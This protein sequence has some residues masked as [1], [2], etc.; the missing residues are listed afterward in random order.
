[1]ERFRQLLLPAIIFQSVLIG[2]AYATGREIVEYGARFGP[3]GLW[4]ML[5]IFIGFTTLSALTYEFARVT[6][7]FDYRSLVRELIGPAW[8]LFDALFITLVII[9]IAVVS[10]ASGA[11]AEQVLGVPQFAGVLAVMAL[12]SLINAAGRGFIEGFKSIGTAVLYAGYVAFAGSVLSSGG[13]RIAAAMAAPMP[14][15]VTVAAM[16]GTGLLYVGY[17]I[18]GVASVLFTLDQLKSRSQAMLAGLITGVLSTVPFLLTYLAVMVYYPDEAVL[19]AEVPWLVMLGR[20]GGE[21]LAAFYALVVAWTL[22]ETAVGYAHAVTDRVSLARIETGRAGLSARQAGWL[23]AA[24]LLLAA[25]LSRFGIIALVARGYG[26]MAWGFLAL[27]VAPLLTVGVR[28]IWR[29]G[30]AG[31]A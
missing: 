23:A 2:G 15:G 26:A 6:R 25:A 17:N 5:A 7:R 18:I 27:F 14:A 22:V 11:I 1:M 19:G 10:A 4:S 3:G 8:P 13:D 30:S 28:R 12:V 9:V 24:I 20:V 21:G 16:L 29:A 31:R